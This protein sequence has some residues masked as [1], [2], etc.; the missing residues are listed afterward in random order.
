MSE[1]AFPMFSSRSFMMPSRSL[2]HFEFIFVFDVR[3]CSNFIDLHEASSFHY[4]N[5]WK[6]SLFPIIY[7]CLLCHRLIDHRCMDLFLDPSFC[8]INLFQKCLFLYQ[9]VCCFDCRS[10]VGWYEVLEGLWLQLCSLF[11]GLLW[12][13]WAF[14]GCM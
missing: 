2:I 12:Q 10:F 3:E 13:F 7:S 1:N 11:S 9:K 14:C 6:D 5:C 4:T 8:S